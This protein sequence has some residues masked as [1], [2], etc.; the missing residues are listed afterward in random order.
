MPG[1]ETSVELDFDVPLII[2]TADSHIGPRLKEDLRAYC[3]AQYLGEYDEFVQAYEPLSDP[4]RLRDAL[5]GNGERISSTEGR[6]PSVMVN[7]TAGHYD[8]HQ[9]LKDM[10]RDGVAAEVIYHGSQNGQCFPLLPMMGGTFNSMVFSP[11]TCSAHDLELAAVGQHMFN[12]WLADQCSVQPERHAGLAHVP[13]WDI[14]AA[15]K[16]VE[17]ASSAGLK[18]VNFPAPK[19]GIPPY[20][21]PAWEPFWSVCEER[22]MVL[23]THAGTDIDTYGAGGPHTLLVLTITEV[24]EKTLPR[25]VFSGVFERHPGLKLALTEL[26]KPYSRWWPALVREY[27]ELWAVNREKLRDVLLQPPSLYLSCI[28][29]G[30]SLLFLAPEEVQIAVREGY[31]SRYMWGSDYPHGEGPY[32]IPMDDESES[33]SVLSLR[34]AL[35][36]VDPR[37]ARGIAGE[38]AMELYGLDRDKLA[39]VAKEIDAIDLRRLGTPLEAIPED[40]SS[41][42]RS[43]LVFPEYLR[44]TET[45]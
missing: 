18:G 9:R 35:S 2:V 37:L 23:S 15:V 39:A 5:V 24:G 19:L 41:L 17:W 22:G 43:T 12:R 14:D 7:D 40:W 30:N 21:D 11:G 31:A 25:L 34:H 1:E 29:H 3:P 16:E 4:S 42:A 10:D 20:D 44:I 13:M 32:R 33:R 26:Q 6:A 36:S 38:N 45:V 28:Y 27:D 8:V